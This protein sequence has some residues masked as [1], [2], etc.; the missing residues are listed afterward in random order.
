MAFNNGDLLEM[1]PYHVNGVVATAG[2]P[3]TL[4]APSSNK[5]QQIFVQ[6]PS[7]G[8]NA[9]GTNDV[10]YINIDGTSTYIA[11]A[12]GESVALTGDTASIKIDSSIN[13][14]KYEAILWY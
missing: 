11:L 4:T 3:V 9:N 12:R 8:V 7:R 1:T 13:G 10:L 2:V 14:V 5:I 6:N